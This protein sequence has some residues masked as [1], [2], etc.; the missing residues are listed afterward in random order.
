MNRY[1]KRWL[2]AYIA[3]L[4]EEQ[5]IAYVEHLVDR[6][7][8]ELQKDVE[9]AVDEAIKEAH[10]NR[11]AEDAVNEAL[12]GSDTEREIEKTI[13]ALVSDQVND[14]EHLIEMVNLAIAERVKA[15]FDEELAAA[16]DRKER[17]RDR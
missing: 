10:I 9:Y 11:T 2:D 6:A 15:A 1:I 12:T 8:E 14:D 17:E 7:K 5:A 3:P 13:K 4:V 16:D